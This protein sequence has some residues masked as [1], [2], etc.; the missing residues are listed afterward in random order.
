MQKKFASKGEILMKKKMIMVVALLLVM[1]TMAFNSST[2]FAWVGDSYPTADNAFNAIMNEL[3]SYEEVDFESYTFSKHELYGTDLAIRGYCYDFVLDEETPGFILMAKCVAGAN[4]F[5][6]VTEVYVDAEN[7]YKNVTG[8]KLYPTIMSYVSYENGI[9]RELITNDILTLA[10]V[11]QAENIGFGYSGGTTSQT[12]HDVV[13][14]TTKNVTTIQVVAEEIPNYT[15]APTI[16][17]NA[18]ATVAGATVMG[19][20][21]FYKPNLIADYSPAYT[22]G[23]NIYFKGQSS[24]ITTLM[25]SLYTLMGTNTTGDGTTISQFK[26]GMTA[27]ASQN[28]NYSVSY[29]STMTSG[30]YD[31][32]KMVNQFT[33]NIPVAIFLNPYYN[34]YSEENGT[35]SD[36]FSGNDY[37]GSHTIIAYG[38]KTINYY[39]ETGTLFTTRDFLKVAPCYM[40]CLLC[41][42]SL[43]TQYLS[44][45]DS[46]GIAVL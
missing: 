45:I 19:Y 28:G 30:A 20:W 15:G 46:F 9:Y 4:V 24:T 23:S 6:E 25:N 38:R 29:N 27:Y 22:Y 1:S 37:I 2:C 40:D 33:N 31:I 43:T 16:G 34:F 13:D 5:Y 39:N 21:D 26:T 44:V 3:P 36:T 41:L 11:Q 42:T 12:E 18:C 8:Q 10:E 17:G 7:P 14:Y 35:N 32:N